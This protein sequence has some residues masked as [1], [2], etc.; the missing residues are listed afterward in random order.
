MTCEISILKN[1][2][3]FDLLKS[4]PIPLV[5][6]RCR[7]GKKSCQRLGHIWWLP[8]P[9]FG[10]PSG[11]ATLPR[12]RG[13]LSYDLMEKW[14]GGT[15]PYILTLLAVQPGWGCVRLGTTDILEN[16]GL[17][18]RK[19]LGQHPLCLTST[20]SYCP[21]SFLVDIVERGVCGSPFWTLVSRAQ[22]FFS[23]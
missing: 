5:L 6:Y 7:E 12:A 8:S 15:E 22:S 21:S 10:S 23:W 3:G 16:V 20:L 18:E 17:S 4:Q 2:T 13:K 9:S 1:E 19:W 14:P 11:Q